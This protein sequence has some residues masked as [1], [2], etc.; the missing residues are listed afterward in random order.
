M[1]A[2]RFA[3]F[4]GEHAQRHEN[5]ACGIEAG[6]D[7]GQERHIGRALYGRREIYQ[8]EQEPDDGA[9][10][11]EDRAD[12]LLIGNGDTAHVAGTLGWARGRGVEA[13]L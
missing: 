4:D 11:S 13:A 1:W 5:R 6:V 12:G 8:P 10:D 2:S 7:G 9:A 3:V